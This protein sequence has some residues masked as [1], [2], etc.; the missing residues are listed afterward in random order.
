MCNF[1][2]INFCSINDFSQIEYS[3]VGQGGYV[4]SLLELISRTHQNQPKHIYV[5]NYTEELPRKLQK[6]ESELSNLQNHPL[7]LG[8]NLFQLEMCERI[9]PKLHSSVQLFDV[10]AAK[11]NAETIELFLSDVPI[12]ENYVLLIA[13]N[14]IEN[15]Q[16]FLENFTAWLKNRDI[17]VLVRHPLQVFEKNLITSAVGVFI[18]NGSMPI[19]QPFLEKCAELVTNVTYIECGFFPQQ[20]YFY[21]DRCGVNNRSQ[22]YNDDLNWVTNQMI[23]RVE[24][25]Q[26][27]LYPKTPTFCFEH[28]DYIFVP[29]QVPTDSNVLNHSRFNNGMQEFISYIEHKYPDQN[30]I[31]KPHPKDRLSDSYSFSHGKVSNLNTQQLIFH[32][33]L[34]VGI[35][36]SVLYEAALQGKPVEVEG[37]CL[38]AKHSMQT[39]KLLAAMFYRQFDINEWEFD[40]QKLRRFSFLQQGLDN[41]K[42]IM[43][44]NNPHQQIYKRVAE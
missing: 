33:D 6:L 27:E 7:I 18:W 4:M 29:L 41:K 21:F 13:I 17:Q 31:F 12:A 26:S 2:E 22:L 8:S 14:P 19:H 5:K 3:I 1:P 24:V 9:T 40:Q 20:Q 37:D 36:T 23:E 44:D 39:T 16:N 28:S 11:G 43:D 25:L 35:N 32:A 38:L 30:V 34:V 15:I 10:A 42:V